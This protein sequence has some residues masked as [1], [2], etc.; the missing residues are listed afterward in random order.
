MRA[1]HYVGNLNGV[2]KIMLIKNLLYSALDRRF[3]RRHPRKLELLRNIFEQKS[4]SDWRH[5]LVALEMGSSL[6]V[7]IFTVK[8]VDRGRE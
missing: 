1:V 7:V 5:L 2:I 4:T 6:S 8:L 3:Y